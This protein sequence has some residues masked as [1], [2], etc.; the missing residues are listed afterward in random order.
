MK[1]H[2]PLKFSVTDDKDVTIKEFLDD[3]EASLFALTESKKRKQTL[4]L[5]EN[6]TGE[7]LSSFGLL[8][9]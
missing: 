4:L 8:I 6:V 5:K 3:V 7:V 1:K 2:T 9:D